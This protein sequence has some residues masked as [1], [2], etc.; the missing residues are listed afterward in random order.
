V[1]RSGLGLG[2][3]IGALIVAW[4]ASVQAMPEHGGGS[5]VIGAQGIAF[6][7][8]PAESAEQIG[9]L[10]LDL[11]G[12][13]AP[14]LLPVGFAAGASYHFGASVPGGFVY[15]LLL[16][17]LG[18]AAFVDGVGWLALSGGGDLNGVT[19]R[20]AFAPR[21]IAELRV[22]ID[23]PGPFHLAAYAQ[24]AWLAVDSRQDGATGVGFADEIELGAGLRIGSERVR[25]GIDSSRGLFVGGMW[26]QWLGATGYGLVVGYAVDGQFGGD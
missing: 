14:G 9:T 18:V 22:E 6:D 1:A 20:V 19:S 23:V 26:R 12:A 13:I 21:A 24:P 17:P 3:R 5:V 11:R 4:G 15:Q 10:G 25:H 2:F 8:A 16:L 7:G